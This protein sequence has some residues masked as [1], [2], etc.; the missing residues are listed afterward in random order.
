MKLIGQ[1]VR[2][3]PDFY[4]IAG[5]LHVYETAIR[6]IGFTFRIPSVISAF[7]LWAECVDHSDT[8]SRSRFLECN[9]RTRGRVFFAATGALTAYNFFRHD[10]PFAPLLRGIIFNGRVVG[11]AGCGYLA[12]PVDQPRDSAPCA[13]LL[14]KA[15]CSASCSAR[16]LG[17]GG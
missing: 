8:F 3:R 15:G 16:P 12:N 1:T 5:G 7:A 9:W 4:T 17:F 2:Y 11:I 10:L 13:R 14:C 6:E